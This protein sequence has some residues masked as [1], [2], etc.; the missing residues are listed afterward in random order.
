M[1]LSVLLYMS[2]DTRTR[3]CV[4]VCVCVCAQNTWKDSG[5]TVDSGSLREDSGLGEDRKR[6]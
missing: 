5:Q 2:T 1:Y 3:I 4:C 6:R